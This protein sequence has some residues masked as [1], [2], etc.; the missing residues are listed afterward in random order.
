VDL[1]RINSVKRV[2]IPT[3]YAR[4]LRVILDLKLNNI[5]Y[6]EYIKERVSKLI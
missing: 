3:T 2:I 6:I 5:K 1:E 4:Y